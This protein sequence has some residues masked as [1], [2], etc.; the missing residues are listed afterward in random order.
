MESI[1]APAAPGWTCPFCGADA[2]PIAPTPPCGH[3]FVVDGENGWRYTDDSRRLAE[4]AAAKDPTLF[5]ELLYH[6]PQC[7]EHL[8]LRRAN[9]D[10]SLEMYVFSGDPAATVCAFETAI[11]A[12]SPRQQQAQP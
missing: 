12:A 5:R 3:L 9:Y 2:S 1:N 4:A 10:D 7:R 8:R 11:T 6:D